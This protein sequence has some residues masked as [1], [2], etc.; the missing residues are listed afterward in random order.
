MS[1]TLTDEIQLEHDY[2]TLIA[3]MGYHFGGLFRLIRLMWVRT[4]V[5]ASYYKMEWDGIQHEAITM[6]YWISITDDSCVGEV[7]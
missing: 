2:H 4:R 5:N 6:Q 1:Y 3:R 7:A